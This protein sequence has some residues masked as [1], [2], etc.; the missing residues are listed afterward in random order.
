ME[1]FQS[2][3]ILESTQ[4]NSFQLFKEN[5]RLVNY[6]KNLSSLANYL[7]HFPGLINKLIS[8]ESPHLHRQFIARNVQKFSFLVGHGICEG[9]ACLSDLSDG[10]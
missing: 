8:N 6:R 4:F 2:S 5:N 3:P 10:R 1:S 7:R 9:S